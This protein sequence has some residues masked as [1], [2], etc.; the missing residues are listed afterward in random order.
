[1]QPGDLIKWEDYTQWTRADT[2]SVLVGIIIRRLPENKQQGFDDLV[3]LCN[4]E[5]LLWCSWQCEV[6]NGC[7]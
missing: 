1:M 6:I 4:G 5:E 3:V 2:P 7:R